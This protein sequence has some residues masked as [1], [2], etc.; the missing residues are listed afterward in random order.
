[1]IAIAFGDKQDERTRNLAKVNRDVAPQ[2][3]LKWF[4]QI[5]GRARRRIEL[6]AP[7]P[8]RWRS[9]FVRFIVPPAGQT[10]Q[11]AGRS[12]RAGAMLDL[13]FDPSFFDLDVVAE[14]T[15]PAAKREKQAGRKKSRGQGREARPPHARVAT[16][17]PEHVLPL[18]FRK[19]GAG[20][21]K[22]PRPAKLKSLVR[23]RPTDR[24][25]GTLSI[26]HLD[27]DSNSAPPRRAIGFSPTDVDARG[28][29]MPLLRAKA[30]GSHTAEEAGL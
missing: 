12:G 1:M 15:L 21:H 30:F 27:A 14:R 8:A 26:D 10:P 18:E 9:D 17:L 20:D 4:A 28:L 7:K 13:F 29:R 5:K 22:A 19:I 16:N 6:N 11:F 24:H 2:R 25:W 3:K 23:S